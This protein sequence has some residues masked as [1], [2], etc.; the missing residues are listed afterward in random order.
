MHNRLQINAGKPYQDLIADIIHE[1]DIMIKETTAAGFP[2]D[3]IIIDPDWVRQDTGGKPPGDQT[4]GV[5]QK[6]GQADSHRASR[7]IY[8][9]SL[10]VKVDQ[11]L[12]GV[13]PF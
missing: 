3:K 11:R 10:D 8:R 1:L 6:P 9:P 12:E 5:F 2:E 4:T 7:R 13:W